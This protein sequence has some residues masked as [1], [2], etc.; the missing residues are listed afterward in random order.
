MQSA[1]GLTYCTCNRNKW[2]VGGSYVL[3]IKEEKISARTKIQIVIDENRVSAW[4][5]TVLDTAQRSKML[6]EQNFRHHSP[7]FLQVFFYIFSFIL[8]LNA[9]F[10]WFF[11]L[12]ATAMH[13]DSFLRTLLT[14]QERF[15]G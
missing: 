5:A 11:L 7:P 8:T 1:V 10:A 9:D 3:Y 13:T 12:F 15:V 14:A 4:C 6:T 2:V